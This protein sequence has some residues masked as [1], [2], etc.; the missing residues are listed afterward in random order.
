MRPTM[1]SWHSAS[2][3]SGGAGH[4]T[5]AQLSGFRRQRE[6]SVSVD[7]KEALLRE[8]MQCSLTTSETD[9]RHHRQKN[10]KALR[11]A[12]GFRAPREGEGERQGKGSTPR[13]AAE[14][15]H[16]PSN[17]IHLRIVEWHRQLGWR[18]SPRRGR[19]HGG[20]RQGPAPRSGVLPSAS[21]FLLVAK[22]NTASGAS[23]R[24]AAACCQASGI[25]H[26][27]RAGCPASVVPD[28]RR[29]HSLQ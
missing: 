7:P 8:V 1:R 10:T 3:S 4:G 9:A 15:R 14:S 12:R 28:C 11:H 18:P 25:C 19:I 29:R 13:P 27:V 2:P 6:R 20:D 5:E 16:P 17:G 24:R 21:S 26:A 22:F 23:F